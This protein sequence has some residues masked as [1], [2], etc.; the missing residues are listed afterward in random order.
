MTLEVMLFRL[1]SCYDI[2]KI[3][4]NEYIICLIFAY[5]YGENMA[6]RWKVDYKFPV[7]LKL[8]M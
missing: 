5:I 2:D 3:D 8:K 7:V 4:T 1:S 6:T